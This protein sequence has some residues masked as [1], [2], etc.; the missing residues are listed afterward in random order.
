MEVE[1][2]CNACV[3]ILISHSLYMAEQIRSQPM[4]AYVTWVTSTLCGKG[5][6]SFRMKI[7]SVSIQL[8]Y[9]A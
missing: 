7:I 1:S 8:Q 5:P 9:H 6:F 4:R 3:C 2:G